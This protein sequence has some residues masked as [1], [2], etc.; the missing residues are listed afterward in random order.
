MTEHVR[1]LIDCDPGHD[2]ALALWT[3]ADHA[4]IVGITTVHGNAPLE[5]TTRNA[6]VCCELAGL[7]VPVHAGAERPMVGEPSYGEAVH[8]A[9]GLD[10][11]EPVEPRR[12][13]DGADAVGFLI[14]TIRGTEGLWLVATGPLT[15]VASALR[16]APDLVDRLAGVSLMGGSTGAGN[17]TPVAEFNVLADPEAAAIVF[18]CGARPLVMSGLNLTMQF[19]VD[20]DFV[21]HVAEVDTPLTRFCAAFLDFYLD[22]QSRVL[23]RRTGPAHDVCAV[24]AVTHTGLLRTEARHV[25][26]E[27][28]GQLTRGMTVVDERPFPHLAERA[29]TE[30]A[31]GIDTATARRVLLDSI[32]AAAR[33]GAS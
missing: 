33:R 22:R 18:A 13:P 11:P 2:D 29:N 20:D 32:H 28:T 17:R 7:D 14:D 4:E 30:V 19:A 25:D 26:V 15:N 24:L 3:A 6:L 5:H 31:Y 8:G 21:A 9:T 12:P 23:G 16:R 1:L 10:G 27:L